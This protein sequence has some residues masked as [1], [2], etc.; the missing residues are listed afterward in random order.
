MSGVMLP[1]PCVGSSTSSAIEGLIDALKDDDN[2]VRRYAARAL[3]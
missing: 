3:G 2:Y 1:V